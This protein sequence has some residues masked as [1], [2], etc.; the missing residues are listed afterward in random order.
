MPRFKK[1]YVFISI[2]GLFCLFINF[3]SFKDNICSRQPYDDS[4]NHDMQ[5]RHGGIELDNSFHLKQTQNPKPKKYDDPDDIGKESLLQIPLPKHDNFSD[6]IQLQRADSRRYANRDIGIHVKLD[7]IGEHGKPAL[8]K[9]TAE[10]NSQAKKDYKDHSFNV[11]ISDMISVHRSLPDGRHKLCRDMN[12]TAQLPASSVVICFHNEAWSVLLRTVHSVLDRTPDDILLEVLLIDD[13]S[14]MHHLHIQLEEHMTSY[15]K[16]KIVRSPERLGLIRARLLGV[17]VAKADVVTFLDSHCEVMVGWLEPQLARIG[18]DPTVIVTPVV[19]Q[20]NKENFE[21]MVLREPFQ[22]GGFNWRL[23]YR[24]KPVPNYN[25]RKDP[26]SPIRAPAMPGGLFSVNKTF[27]LKLGGFDTGMKI[28]GGENL[29]ESIKIWRC[30]GS[31]EILP[32]SRVGHVY[33]DTQPYSFPGNENIMDVIERNAARVAEVW[34]DDYKEQF[35]KRLPHLRNI[36]YGDVSERKKLLENLQ[37]KSF[38]WYLHNAYPEMYVPREENIVASSAMVRNEGIDMC[39]DSNDQ[40]GQSGKRLISWPCHGL[41][42]N[43]YFELTKDGE[44]RNDELCLQ[45][46]IGEMYVVLNDC[47]KNGENVPS[48]Q[49]WQYKNGKISHTMTQKCMVA[50]SAQ[51]GGDIKLTI[52]NDTDK[53]QIWT[54]L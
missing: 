11:Y 43:E 53:K 15:N 28:W 51:R 39:I 4:F 2:I 48:T 16:V 50:V 1:A 46:D 36:D 37:C 19:D 45:P 24:W 29:E 14:T 38:E 54:F 3:T 26:T 17:D 22:R 9:L 30:N 52:C 41:G 44:I 5:T 21:Y 32:C 34:L 31:I 6:Q 23:L 49:K 10:E 27:F 18:E 13:A 42:G 20:I 12:Y 47:A 7:G 25:E 33:R 40:N 35:Y 8:P